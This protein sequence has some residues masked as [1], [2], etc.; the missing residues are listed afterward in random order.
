MSAS[1]SGSLDSLTDAQVLDQLRGVEADRRRLE[2][3]EAGL[4]GQVRRR[5]LAFVHGC[6]D[7]VAFLRHLLN[8]GAGDAAARVKLAAA[9]NPRRSYAGEGLPAEH[10]EVAAAFADGAICG[11]AAVTIARTVDKLPADTLDLEHGAGRAVETVLVDFAR[12][13]DPETLRR[14]ATAVATALDQDG[15][16]RDHERRER[17]RDVRLS[18]RPDGSGTAAVEMTAELAEYL[19]TTLD[20]LG[21]PQPGGDGTP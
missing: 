15:A 1:V 12:D 9:V 16:Y 3:R 6:K 21:R 17:T 19:H 7:D 5:G 20:C 14:H 4:V 2:I 10:P 8:I 18:R 13:N 11:A